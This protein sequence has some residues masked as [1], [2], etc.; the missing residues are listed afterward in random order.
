MLSPASQP[1]VVIEAA[2]VP[3]SPPSPEV[4]AM[5]KKQIAKAHAQLK[6]FIEEGI[7]VA[8]EQ[9]V[10]HAPAKPPASEATVRA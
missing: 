6:P 9:P 7:Q 10:V 5:D 3:A 8:N 1:S 4:L 2:D